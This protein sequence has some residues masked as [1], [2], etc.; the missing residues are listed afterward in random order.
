MIV[1]F[2]F[3]FEILN[4]NYIVKMELK[5]IE[6]CLVKA[7]YENSEIFNDDCRNTFEIDNYELNTRIDVTFSD[8]DLTNYL[9][10]YFKMTTYVNEYKISSED[11]PMFWNCYNCISNDNN[12][13]Y[14]ESDK[15]IYFKKP[16]ETIEGYSYHHD[17]HFSF[18][19]NSVLELNYNGIGVSNSYYKFTEQ[20]HFYI[21]TCNIYDDI[22]IINFNTTELFKIQGK[23]N[24]YTHYENK[25]FLLSYET[26]KNA[27]QFIGL[28]ASG[29][30]VNLTNGDL[31]QVSNIKG[32]RYILSEEEQAKHG[33]YLKI[34]ITTHTCSDK[35]I[36]KEVSGQKVFKIYICLTGYNFYLLGDELKCLNDGYYEEDGNF[37]SCYETCSNREPYTREGVAQNNIYQMSTFEGDVNYINCE[38]CQNLMT[39]DEK[40]VESC[41]LNNYKYLLYNRLTCYDQIPENYY[42]FVN[43]KEERYY[44][45]AKYEDTQHPVININTYCPGNYFFNG[46][47]V[48]N[49]EDLFYLISPLELKD[50]TEPVLLYMHPKKIFLSTVHSDKLDEIYYENDDGVKIIS[51]QRCKEILSIDF[52]IYTI[53][54]WN[55]NEYRAKIF[56]SDGTEIDINLCIKEEELINYFLPND[57]TT[58]DFIKC[59]DECAECSSDSFHQN[60][61]IR[62]DNNKF[63]YQIY[64]F[65]D[66]E[67]LECVN[68]TTKPDDVYL[69]KEELRYEPCFETCQYCSDYGDNK[70]HNCTTCLDGYT[71]REEYPTNC[72]VDCEML[73]YYNEFGQ[74]R[75]TEST[76]CPFD[77]LY[78]EEKK[79]CV[80]NCSD[81]FPY[82]YEFRGDCLTYCPDKSIPSVDLVRLTNIC[83]TDQCN[84]K[85]NKIKDSLD[86]LVA[87]EGRII[88]EFAKGYTLNCLNTTESIYNYINENYSFVIYKNYDCLKSFLK[89][90]NVNITKIKFEECYVR[91][92]E[93]YNITERNIVITL[94]DKYRG[95]LAPYNIYNF[96]DPVTGEKLNTSICQ[97]TKV[98]K[99]VDL[100][101][102]NMKNYD[103][104]KS[105]LEQGIDIFNYSSPFFTDICFHFESP[106]GRDITLNQRASSYYENIK[107][108]DTGCQNKGINFTSYEAICECQFENII[109]NE[110]LNQFIG[111]EIMDLIGQT[112]IEVLKCYEDVFKFEYFKKNYGCMIILS[113]MFIQIICTI[114]YYANDLFEMQRF[115]YGIIHYFFISGNN[116]NN[117]NDKDNNKNKKIMDNSLILK[118]NKDQ[119]TSIIEKSKKKITK[120]DNFIILRGEK[121]DVLF[122]FDVNSSNRYFT[123]HSDKEKKL[124]LDIQIFKNKDYENFKKNQK[125]LN[126]IK[127]YQKC[128][129]S[130]EEIDIF[131]DKS[132]NELD[133]DD[134]IIEDTRGFIDMFTDSLL[135]NHI[136]LN[137]MFEE[138]KYKPS[139]IKI[140]IYTLR[141]DLYF[142]VN[143]LFYSQSYIDELYNLEE[144]ETFWSF[145]F[146][147][148]ERIVYTSIIGKIMDFIIDFFI[149]SGD[150]IKKKLDKNEGSKLIIK[151]EISNLSFEIIRNIHIFIFINFFIMLISF[152]YVSCFNNVFP[153]TKAEWIK[154][155]VFI[156]V[157]NEIISFLYIFATTLLRYL[158]IT[159]KVENF[160]KL[161]ERINQ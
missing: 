20:P 151:G 92:Q 23:D 18:Q 104:K 143:G 34:T 28:D 8:T 159:Y 69:N 99:E 146:R 77:M 39:N 35:T 158:S 91:L 9:A 129:V 45:D 27:G 86:L 105:L 135:E 75:C 89:D 106:N 3:L 128:N 16:E 85:Q 88:N 68:E 138:D 149:I 125:L 123:D 147:A 118:D 47:C 153:N 26:T 55:T 141:I 76:L 42:T 127:K 64:Y 17:F 110:L 84:L 46:I 53:H 6:G 12:F 109:D 40:C 80:Y 160:F 96:Y 81:N 65:F 50:Y 132:L 122:H 130:K 137:S 97:D 133:Y 48:N 15:R 95:K 29:N 83:E 37:Y 51:V 78:I 161:A 14:K 82:I 73:Y 142:V 38:K 120:K 56:K 31:F 152:Y 70:R 156:Y 157:I 90:N 93:L 24:H 1:A 102:L 72:V 113:L 63:Y 19:I 124:N 79:K 13:Y 4:S 150:K 117:I 11:Y 25:G 58:G 100:L 60:S 41:T 87:D 107:L 119:G 131:M 103:Y 21:T 30:D 114:V 71:M 57:T 148:T 145:A 5:E 49:L 54:D 22:D 10:G 115:T 112:N 154:S 121:A 94:F 108:C 44:P 7:I 67:F 62:C 155:S 140:V 144:E 59:P 126:F 134:A 66:T 43:H 33:A 111:D 52:L 2:S 116:Q 36:S 32:L 136:F 98:E 139:S 74:Y 61:C 101:D